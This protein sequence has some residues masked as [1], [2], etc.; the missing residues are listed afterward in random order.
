MDSSGV[1]GD[2]TNSQMWTEHAI[3]HFLFQLCII[4]SQY[5]VLGY[6]IIH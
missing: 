6:K 4:Q 3:Y 1:L 5:L 2:K